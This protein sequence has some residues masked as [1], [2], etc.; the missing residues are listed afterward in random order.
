MKTKT[1]RIILLFLSIFFLFAL[2]SR[3]LA[4]GEPGP[5]SA[6]ICTAVVPAK[7]WLY[8]IKTAG[9]NAVDLFWDKADRATNWT[10]AY[11][12]QSGKYIYGVHNFG[13]SSS[14]GIRINLLPAGKYFFVVRANN[15]CMP[16]PFSDEKVIT[17]GG[18]R[19]GTGGS[20]T[21]TFTGSGGGGQWLSPTPIPQTFKG[22]TV[23]PTKAQQKYTTP[24]IA[25][26]VTP[27]PKPMGFF[28]RFWQGIL[29]LF[30]LDK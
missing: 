7:A 8:M 17:L 11:G 2:S 21:T 22:Q 5:A 3:V 15:G 16:G 28:Q 10:V 30:G 24:T 6:P 20:E 29:R 26:Y 27:T 13:D 1:A 4:Y 12:V 18:V 19:E 14:R 23:S 25:P 9:S